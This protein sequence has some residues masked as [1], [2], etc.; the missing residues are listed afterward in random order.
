MQKEQKQHIK[1][2]FLNSLK[3]YGFIASYLYPCTDNIYLPI[4]FEK[5]FND[6]LYSIEFTNE[7]DGLLAD[8]Y[9]YNTILFDEIL[10]AYDFD[11]NMEDLEYRHIQKFNIYDTKDLDYVL[12][13]F[14]GNPLDKSY[15]K[16]EESNDKV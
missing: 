7:P 4:Q 11:G 8:E 12:Y 1:N 5:Q 9:G 14:F 3:K 13:L 6:K 16:E 15:T 2:I 10:I